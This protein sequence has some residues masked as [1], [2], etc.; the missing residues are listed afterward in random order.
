MIKKGDT[1]GSTYGHG[2]E[3]IFGNIISTTYGQTSVRAGA[4]DATDSYVSP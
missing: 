2:T 4:E 1:E 3:L